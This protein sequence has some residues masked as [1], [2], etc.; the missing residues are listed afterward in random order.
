MGSIFIRVQGQMGSIGCKVKI[1]NCKFLPQNHFLHFLG[2]IT[3]VIIRIFG[4][5]IYVRGV[6]KI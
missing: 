3:H 2:K 5:K 4:V 1:K 6:E